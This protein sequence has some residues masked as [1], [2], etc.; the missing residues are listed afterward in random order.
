MLSRRCLQQQFLLRPDPEVEKNYL[1]CLGVAA[2][3]FGIILIGW[4]AMSDHKHEIVLDPHGNY[5][6]FIE[7]FHGSLARVMNAHWGRWEN[8]WAVGQPSVVR[9][10]G[11]ETQFEK[12]I[13]VLTNPV[14]AGLVDRV[15]DWPGASSYGQNIAGRERV[16]PR[17]R[18]FRDEGP[19]PEAVTLR[20]GR[21]PGFEELTDDEWRDKIKKAVE[22]KENELRDERHRTGRSILG[23]K[24][25]L[26]ASHLDSPATIERRRAL[27]PHIACKDDER[28]KIELAM[29][30]GFRAAYRRARL[31][32]I[33]G[34]REA[35]FP[36]GTYLMRIVL[37]IRVDPPPTIPAAA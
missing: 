2:E 35:V 12:L 31:L 25:V 19:L 10:V 1:Y 3:R 21:L 23:R 26:A 14:T 5:P 34:D 36:F 13:Y 18:F 28:R 30:K 6:R 15:A 17:P 27:S 24:E 22:A 20:T 8:F 32:W 16:V 11:A 33:D 37:G 29:L 7:F 9:L 4:T